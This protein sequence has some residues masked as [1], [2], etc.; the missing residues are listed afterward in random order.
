[1]RL[2]IKNLLRFYD[3]RNPL[4]APHAAGITGLI[5]E[6]FALG[7]LYKYLKVRGYTVKP[8]DSPCT[9]GTKKGQ[10]LDKWIRVHRDNETFLFQTEV[11]NWSVHSFGG[12]HIAIDAT[13]EE[14]SRISILMWSKYWNPEKR[15][16]TDSGLDKVRLPMRSP[17]P[18]FLIKP[19]VVIWFPVHPE[20]LNFPMFEVEASGHFEKV[21]VFSVSTFLRSL[22]V[23]TLD[24]DLPR[25]ENRL[26]ILNSL[27]S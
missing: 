12:E 1:M 21:H 4:N 6:D 20:G 11:K 13:S 3:E 2:N 18:G 17:L 24:I 19:L 8:L 7:V 22:E 15:R 25:V 23:E 14:F 5:G 26:S 10:R 27:V 9:Q 16:F